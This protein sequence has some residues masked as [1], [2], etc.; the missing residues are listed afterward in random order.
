M[1]FRRR[2]VVLAVLLATAG[3]VTGIATGVGPAAA[4][5]GV[6]TAGRATAPVGRVHWTPCADQ[7]GDG[8]RAQCGTITVPLD[9][10]HP[11]G[12]RI[13]LALS[14]LPAADPAQRV[15]SLLFNPG[16]PGG[17]GAETVAQSGTELFSQQLRDRF[18][19]VGFD[20]RGT[21]ESTSVVCSGAPLIS[22]VPVFP[23]NAAQFAA[24]RRQSARYGRSCQQQTTPGLLQHVD[25]VSAARDIDAI[26]IAL[27][28]KQINWLGVS[29]GTYL[30]QTYAR[31]FPNRIRTMVLDGAMDHA[32]GP[33]AFL[34]EEA[35]AVENAF[36]RFAAWCRTSADC[37]MHGQNVLAVWDRLIAQ[38][39]RTPI[40]APQAHT[41]LD[42]AAIDMV[43]PEILIY[44]PTG[45][46][47]DAPW[48]ELAQGI[49]DAAKGD[50][51]TLATIT[52]VG[53][54]QPAYIAV[55]C[56]DFPPQFHGATDALARLRVAQAVSP[57]THGASEAWM[58]SDGCADWPVP[59]ADPWADQPITNAP[60]ILVVSSLHD[61]STPLI[62]AQGLHGEIRGSR[63][64]TA[65]VVGHTA[66]LNSECARQQEADYLISGKLPP[67]GTTC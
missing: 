3:A 37:P 50:A 27:G 49:A 13:S 29:Y 31:L 52:P 46:F 11:S 40:P 33:Q 43:L 15:G 65:D 64:L 56:H 32:T 1:R 12:R 67:A 42:G 34:I 62:W 24:V 60:P 59:A 41:A 63:L 57:H 51:S 23:K 16:G 55:S 17:P 10:A 53:E 19:I 8:S 66:Y 61:P 28:E 14:R 25:T 54:P 30:G 6:G 26:R 2:G 44:G 20:P 7:E 36:E 21:G 22:G 58:I 39:N 18:D 48:I 47:G 38:A 4:A 9:W 5:A 35:A 45:L